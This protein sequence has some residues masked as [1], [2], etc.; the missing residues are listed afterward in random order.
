MSF[1]VRGPMPA[2]LAARLS[3]SAGLGIHES[4]SQWGACHI[5]WPN[6]ILMNG[7]KVCGILVESTGSG[8]LVSTAVIGVGI[9]VATA[10]KERAYLR[11]VA[12]DVTLQE[13]QDVVV[14][15]LDFRIEELLTVGLRPQVGA[16]N[17][18]LWKGRGSVNGF[19]GVC[20]S[21]SP[22]GHLILRSADGQTKRVSSA[23]I[24]WEG[25]A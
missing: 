19:S 17:E 12:P 23:E 5:K 13:V 25:Y 18:R 11:M 15:R 22:A 1:L 8:N 2:E 7:K 24:Q 6:D 16:I 4:L 14:Q 21:L 3:L 10:P 9:N 20:D